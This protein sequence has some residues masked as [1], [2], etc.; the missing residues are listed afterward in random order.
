MFNEAAFSSLKY[1]Y[2]GSKIINLNHV[3]IDH[4]KCSVGSESLCEITFIN[5]FRDEVLL[6]QNKENQH[7]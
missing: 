4:S 6:S 5:K 2:F 3:I 7:N 1:V